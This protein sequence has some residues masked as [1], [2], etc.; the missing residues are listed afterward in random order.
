MQIRPLEGHRTQCLGNPMSMEM[1]DEADQKWYVPTP[2]W[3]GAR[4]MVV[5]TWQTDFLMAMGM[6]QTGFRQ[7]AVGTWSQAIKSAVIKNTEGCL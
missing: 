1:R 5:G 2:W 3:T 6:Q 4:Q 7:M